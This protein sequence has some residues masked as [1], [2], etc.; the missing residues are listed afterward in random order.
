MDYYTAFKRKYLVDTQPGIRRIFGRDCECGTIWTTVVEL[1]DN[2]ERVRVRRYCENCGSVQF[3]KT[4]HD[5][6][7]LLVVDESLEL[8]EDNS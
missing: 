3:Y 5:P 6:D 8:E 1:V 7:E 4:V 2:D